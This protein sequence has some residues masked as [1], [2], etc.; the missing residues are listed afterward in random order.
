MKRDHREQQQVRIGLVG[1][2]W[3]ADLWYLPVLQQHPDV[4]IA[5]ICS[6]NGENA[7]KMAEKYQIPNTYRSYQ[8]MLAAEELDGV[9]IVTP[10]HLHLPV[11]LYAVD[12]GVHVLCEKPLALDGLEAEQ[13]LHHVTESGMVHGVNFTYREHPG[14]RKIRH[15]IEQQAIGTFLS[16]KF[17]YSGDYGLSGP[18]GWR[19]SVE[20]GGI[21]GV[22]ADLGSH[23]I[24][25]VQYAV[26]Q[27]LTHVQAS[28]KFLQEG[29]LVE[30]P[31]RTNPDQAADSILFSGTFDNG[32]H[33]VFQTS[34]ISAQGNR[35]QTIEM[36][37]HGSEGSLHLLTSELGTKLWYA[38]NTGIQKKWQPIDIPSLPGWNDEAEPS[39]Q[40]FRPWRISEKNEIWKWVDAIRDHA[41]HSDSPHTDSDEAEADR[42]TYADGAQVQRVMDAIIQSAIEGKRVEVPVKP[43][44]KIIP[45]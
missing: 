22:L 35:N 23:L 36:M 37:L 20:Q 4:E 19:G 25:F 11:T 34:W 16:G 18:P 38:P 26:Q 40:R 1:A 9:C 44:M 45:S 13:M 14:I 15:M 21:D 42:P 10:N 33:A 32:A 31:E 30:L 41:A 8:D 7:V 39:E 2:S 27:K 17:E 29:K 43:F 5:A 6:R 12:R 3:F 28:M 24:D